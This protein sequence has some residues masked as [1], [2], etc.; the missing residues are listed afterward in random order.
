MNWE[1][2]SCEGQLNIFDLDTPIF[3]IKKPIRLIELFAGVGSQAMALRDLGADFEHYKISEWEYNA[4]SSY[5]AIH[6]GEN[7]KDYSI[8]MSR[9]EVVDALFELCISADGKEPMDKKSIERKPEQWQRK[10]YNEFKQCNNLGSIIKIHGDDLEIID[11]D[12][13]CYMMTYSFPC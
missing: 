12:N 2:Y 1:N 10:I 4:N 5:R 6:C 13:Y 9:K 8:G 7:N 11:T 3:K